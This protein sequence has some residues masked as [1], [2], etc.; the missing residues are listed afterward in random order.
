MAIKTP[1]RPP[2]P[3]QRRWLRTTVFWAIIIVF[4][5]TILALTLPNNNLK[6]VAFSDVINRGNAGQLSKIEIQGNELYITTQ[7]QED[8]S[9]PTEKSYKEAGSSIYEQGLNQ[10]AKSK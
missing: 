6:E 8:K 9:K 7:A 1:K 2:K 3:N 5:L 4:G 10:D